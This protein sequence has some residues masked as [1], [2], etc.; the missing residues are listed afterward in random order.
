MI[1]THVFIPHMMTA[2]SRLPYERSTDVS[3][4]RLAQKFQGR[5]LTREVRSQERRVQ[6]PAY[7]IVE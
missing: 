4:M 2:M 1:L 6:R 5:K 7:S 3:S